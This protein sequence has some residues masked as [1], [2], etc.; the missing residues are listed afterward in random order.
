MKIQVLYK[1]P[2]KFPRMINISNKLEAFQKLVKGYI[3]TY[4][5]SP[6]LVVICNEEGRLLGMPANCHF[7]GELFA[8]PIIVCSQKGAEFDSFKMSYSEA[9]DAYPELWSVEL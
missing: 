2:G 4:T 9:L 3:E 5:I 6:D 8:G 7:F 1:E